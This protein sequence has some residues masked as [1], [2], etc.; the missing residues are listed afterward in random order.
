MIQ[1]VVFPLNDPIGR[2][3]IRYPKIAANRML[4]VNDSIGRVPTER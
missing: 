1:S 2:V 4:P 3:F